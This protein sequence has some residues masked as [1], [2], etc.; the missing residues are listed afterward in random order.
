MKIEKMIGYRP[1][2]IAGV[3]ILAFIP[4]VTLAEADTGLT[5]SL[6]RSLKAQGWQED[7][8]EDGSVIYRQTP[9][10]SESE[11]TPLGTDGQQ[12]EQ[13][14]KALDGRGWQA[15]WDPDGSLILRP[16]RSAAVQA[17]GTHPAPTDSETDLIPD[18]PGF[19]YWRIE[20]G[21][22]GA[23]LFHPLPKPP[24]T[25]VTTSNQTAVERCEGYQ[26]DT[27]RVSLPV[28]QWPEANELAQKWLERSGLHGL[29]VGKI[30]KI[31]R[32]Y[33]VSLV[34]DTSPYALKH[35]LAIR[36]SDG[37]VMLLE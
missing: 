12:R 33:L 10:Q 28:D 21:E 29:L 31:L 17:V 16:Q 14:G 32:I 6:K 20:K 37:H 35:Q 8:Q 22:D 9:V 3:L 11:N 19:K 13:F 15:D 30:R 36:A 26:F 24:G 18:L 27:A 5:D 7:Q 2:L 34:D 23:M 1:I 25:E 4:L